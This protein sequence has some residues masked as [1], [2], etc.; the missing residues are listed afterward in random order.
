[1]VLVACAQPAPARP[2][3]GAAGPASK[4]QRTLVVAV[5]GEP[6]SLAVKPLFAFS[7]GLNDPGSVFNATLDFPDE[8]AVTRPYLAE[9]LPQLNTETWRVFPDG[10]MET[11]Y[12]LR[13]NLTW[14]DGAPL[15]AADF[16]FALEV[17]KNPEMGSA[18]SV[19]IAQMEG[20]SAPDARTLVLRWRQA[21]PDAAELNR[22][23]Q[24]LPRHL[25]E[26]PYRDLDAA[27]FAA[28]PFWTTAYI[29]LGPYRLENWEPGAFM[30]GRAFDGHALGRPPIDRV[31]L[32]IIP[33]P[34]TALAGIL[35]GEVHYTGDFVFSQTEG[36]TLEQR[37]AENH[38]GTV[39][40]APTEFRSTNVQVRPE[41]ADPPE[42][43]DVR[44][45]RALAYGIDS[46]TAVEVLTAGR[47]LQTPTITSPK[48]DFYPEIDR[49]IQRHP[50]DQRRVAQL[51]EEVGFVRGG[52]GFF[53]RRDGQTVKLGVWSSAGTKNEQE[54]ATYVDSLRRAGVDASP[55][56][57][58]AAQLGDRR[59]RALLPGLVLRGGGPG[60]DG[61]TSS[62]IAG[63]EN[64]WTGDN[65]YGW[66]NGEY[67]RVFEA[68]ASTLDQQE[69]NSLTAQLER[70]IS[71]E[72]P[73]IPN[74]FGVNVNAVVGPLQGP[75]TRQT[76]G[77]GGPMLYIYT[78]SWRS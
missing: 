55:N 61:L 19:P 70:I 75:V 41:V 25:L 78:W 71:E 17:Y 53:A 74:F 73:I 24:A 34:Q 64:R 2:E 10:A 7:G 6:P 26:A 4:P 27:A 40:Y 13:P 29:G 77:S 68:W 14:H 44:V 43:T 72:L 12:H 20:A 62:A 36:Q 76:P 45:R 39:L 16:V 50:Y 35:S 69:R 23:F 5:R 28:L 9:S 18:A 63:P 57:I 51:L 38:G 54:A 3:A 56:V 48:V 49:V 31:K 58:T 33:D 22:G 46:A 42:L 67:D 21:Y 11:T 37:W 60:L 65:R 59:L 30:E 47:G 32:S 15:S 66:S 8:Q 52:D 1:M